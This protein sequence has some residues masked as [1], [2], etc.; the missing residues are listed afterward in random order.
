[1]TKKLLKI[2][3]H[4]VF[5]NKMTYVALMIACGISI[6]HVLHNNVSGVKIWIE[7]ALN[8]KS[9]M[10]YPYYLYDLWICGNTYNLE[11]FLYFMILPILAVIPHSISFYADKENGYVKQIYTR[12]GRKS[13]LAAKFGAVFL[14]G[15]LVV[16]IPLILNLAICG[17]LLPALQPQQLAGMAINTSVL[18]F[19]IYETHPLLYTIIYLIIDFIFAGLVATLPLFFS[20]FTEK[21]F[22][23]LLMPF[24]M[25]IFI[26]S[27]C[28][29]SGIPNAVQYS[30]VYCIFAGIGCRTVWLLVIYGIGYFMLGGVLY[31]KIAKKEDIF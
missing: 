17:M 22:I 12:V 15:G 9:D 6:F 16:T 11:G 10:Q 30:P 14:T 28:M 7:M 5:K 23:I 3:L 19:Q 18:W 31:W 25:H 13:Y 27:I 24:L 21:K 26:Y 8:L 2:E 4:R 20:F 1:M 29:M